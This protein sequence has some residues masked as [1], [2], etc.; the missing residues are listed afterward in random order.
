MRV[1]VV[2]DE[3]LMADAV[4]EGLRQEATAELAAELLLPWPPCARWSSRSA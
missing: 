1:L 4:A 3:E 2:E